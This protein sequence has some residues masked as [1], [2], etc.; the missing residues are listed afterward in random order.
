MQVK[1]IA[2]TARLGLGFAVFGGG[3]LAALGMLL[4]AQQL[5]HWLA[6]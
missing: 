5:G 1:S 2:R 3:N 4:H 6:H